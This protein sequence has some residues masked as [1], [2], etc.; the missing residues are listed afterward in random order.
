MKTS[1][2]NRGASFSET[3]AGQYA[4]G[5]PYRDVRSNDD[6]GLSPRKQGQGCG[7]LGQS[8]VAADALQIHPVTGHLHARTAASD[9]MQG[10]GGSL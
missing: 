4:H 2:E 10:Y 7:V 8:K 5:R 9:D 1:L 6:G 3:K